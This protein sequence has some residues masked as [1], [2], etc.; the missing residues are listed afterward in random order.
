MASFV[1]G[2]AAELIVE[3][4]LDYLANTIKTG[5]SNTTHVPNKDDQFLD[6]VGADDFID[7]ELSGTGYTAGFGAAGRGADDG[8]LLSKTVVYDTANDRVELDA[9][10]TVWTGINAGTIAQVTLLKEITNDAASVVIANVD[11]ADTVTNGGDI[12]IQW[13]AEGIIQLT[14]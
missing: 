3:Q 7:G 14:V 2:L 10:D 6:D 1:Y 12:T 8:Q 9:A 13:D 11:V 5:L 4:S